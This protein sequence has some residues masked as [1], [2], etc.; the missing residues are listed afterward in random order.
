M[1]ELINKASHMWIKGAERTD[2]IQVLKNQKVPRDQ[3]RIIMDFLKEI[4]ESPATASRFLAEKLNIELEAAKDVVEP[5]LDA[6]SAY[7]SQKGKKG[8][9]NGSIWMFASIIATIFLPGDFFFYAL[10]VYGAYRVI[11]GILLYGKS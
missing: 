4:D 2:I 3:I 8:I 10:M 1:I 7:Y 5:I 11:K 6:Q 9:I